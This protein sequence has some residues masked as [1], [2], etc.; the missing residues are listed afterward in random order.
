MCCVGEMTGLLAVAGVGRLGADSDVLVLVLGAGDGDVLVL[1]LG[2]G[3]VLVLG[4]GRG[5]GLRHV[6]RHVLGLSHVLVADLRPRAE[7]RSWWSD[8]G[9]EHGD[10]E[11]LEPG[12]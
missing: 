12:R 10:M 3:D 8:G 11:S 5:D 2:L 6:V 1:R 4:V 7:V 9:A